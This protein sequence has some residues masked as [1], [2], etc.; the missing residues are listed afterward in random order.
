MKDEY[1]LQRVALGINLGKDPRIYM[2][3]RRGSQNYLGFF[4]NNPQIALNRE[5]V[6]NDK[7]AIQWKLYRWKTMNAVELHMLM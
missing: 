4:L 2:K 1:T 5:M 7:I 6:I 3:T